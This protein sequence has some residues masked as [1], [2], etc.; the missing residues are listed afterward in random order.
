M[1]ER[2]YETPKSWLTLG[3]CAQI[4]ENFKRSL[5]FDEPIPPFETRFKGRLESIVESVSQTFD[6][7]QL[8][9]TILDAASA[10]FYQIISGHPFENGNKRVAVLYTHS[11][12]LINGLDFDLSFNEIYNFAVVVAMSGKGKVEVKEVRDFCS[13]V[14]EKFTKDLDS[15]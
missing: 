12:L 14:I 15:R 7:K 13:E 5:E 9:P 11:F 10:Y 1:T 4:F 8:N 6:G 3:V 2:I